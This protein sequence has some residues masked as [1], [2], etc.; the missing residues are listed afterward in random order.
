MTATTP[1]PAPTTPAADFAAP[2]AVCVFSAA[3]FQAVA[4][5]LVHRGSSTPRIHGFFIDVAAARLERAGDL[6]RQLVVA[7]SAKQIVE[8]ARQI[9]REWEAIAGLGSRAMN[10]NMGPSE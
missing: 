6:Q 3:D 1:T 10:V 7:R 9:G 4:L 2:V 5:P 8:I